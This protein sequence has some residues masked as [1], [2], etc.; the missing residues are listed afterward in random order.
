[1]WSMRLIET[2]VTFNMYFMSSSQHLCLLPKWDV[3]PFN[4]LFNTSHYI[5]FV[6]YTHI[7]QVS[8]IYIPCTISIIYHIKAILRNQGMLVVHSSNERSN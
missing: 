8:V 7:A 2:Q 6:V 5:S 1:M 4:V 3:K